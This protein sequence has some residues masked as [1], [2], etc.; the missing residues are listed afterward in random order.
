MGRIVLILLLSFTLIGCS[1]QNDTQGLTI[2]EENIDTELDVDTITAYDNEYIYTIDR[3]T[4]DLIDKK[5][6]VLSH[7]NPSI[8][9]MD[10]TE[11]TLSYVSPATYYATYIDFCG[12]INCLYENGYHCTKLFSDSNTYDIRLTN[13]DYTVRVIYQN[14]NDVKV[15][16][17][18]SNHVGC[19]PPF[20]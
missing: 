16:C 20:L 9:L 11:Y 18:D 15:L 4:G 13:D 10:Y 6:I 17:E 2:M 5:S 19:V 1:N 3:S 12:Y 14:N 8:Y 7:V